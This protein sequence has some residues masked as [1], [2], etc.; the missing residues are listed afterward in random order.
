MS[1]KER[2]LIEQVVAGWRDKLINLTGKNRLLNFRPG[3]RS[4]LLIEEP[5]IA[6][7]L[8][9][10]LSGQS[11]QIISTESEEES[12]EL[13]DEGEVTSD[14][15]A[16]E[17]NHTSLDPRSPQ[18][19][20]HSETQLLGSP[21]TSEDIR[22]NLRSL[23]DHQS[24]IYLD[25][26]LSVS[27]L[28]IGILEW[29]DP[30]TPDKPFRS[31]LILVPVEFRSLSR[32]APTTL[33]LREDEIATNR[34]LALKLSSLAIDLPVLT[35]STSE[36]L[37]DYLDR[38]EQLAKKNRGWS[39]ERTCIASYFTFHKEAMYQD[40]SDHMDSIAQSELVRAL[41]TSGTDYVSDNLL[42]EP[43]NEVD[44][45]TVDVPEKALQ[46]LDADAS[47]RA[48]IVA[49]RD[50]QSFVL[51]GPPG[52]GKSQTIANIIANQ[53]ALG[54][55]V[56][57]V[58]EK[59]AALEVVK[60][61]LD[62]IGLGSYLLELHSAKAKRSVVAQD[63]GKS[64]HKNAQAQH[65]LK[66]S[67][68]RT[69][70]RNRDALTAYAVAMNSTQNSLGISLHDAIGQIALYSVHPPTP[71]AEF[72][73]EQ[74]DED[75]LAEVLDA[76][77][78]L[79]RAW[80][81]AT[82]GEGFLWAGAKST[83]HP[84]L[85]LQQAIDALEELRLV[86]EPYSEIGET[87]DWDCPPG[88]G[89]TVDLLTALDEA[90][91][92]LPSD[93]LTRED[94]LQTVA[95]AQQLSAL[96][97]Q[98]Q[99]EEKRLA[100]VA[101]IRWRDLVEHQPESTLKKAI[102]P[103][104][105][106]RP[107]VELNVDSDRETLNSLLNGLTHAHS[108]L[109]ECREEANSVASSLGLLPPES[110]QD[111]KDLVEIHDRATGQYRPE[112]SWFK[113][114][115]DSDVERAITTLQALHT[116]RNS[117][118]SK[119][120][121][122]F[123]AKILEANPRELHIRFSNQHTGL[124]RLSSARREDKRLVQE[125]CQA[126]VSAKNAIPL[127]TLAVTW[128]S[129]EEEL[130]KGIDRYSELLGPRYQGDETDWEALQKALENAREIAH[131]ARASAFDQLAQAAAHGSQIDLL[132]RQ[133]VA[134]LG[135]ALEMLPEK[136]AALSELSDTTEL[137]TWSL[138][139]QQTWLEQA[140]VGVRMHIE[141][142]ADLDAPLQTSLT[143]AQAT[144]VEQS[145]REVNIAQTALD[146]ASL[147][148]QSAFPEFSNLREVD[149]D[150]LMTHLEHAEAIREVASQIPSAPGETDA[151][152]PMTQDVVSLARTAGSPE[153]LSAAHQ[154]WIRSRDSIL[155]YFEVDNQLQLLGWFSTWA[156]SQEFLDGLSAD[157]SGP[158]E[159]HSYC[160]ARSR[161]ETWGLGEIIDSLAELQVRS[162]DVPTIIERE[163]LRPWVDFHLSQQTAFQNSLSQ[164]RDSLVSEFA[165]G[166]RQLI[167]TAVADIIDLA[168]SRKP[169]ANV[170]ASKKID[171]EA[172]K[173]TRHIPIRELLD[174]T[175]SVSQKLKPVF[176]MSPLAVSQF[177]SSSLRFDLVIFDE[178][179]QVLPEDAINCI[180][181]ADQLIIA[182]D[183]NQLPP[184]SFF[185]IE[186][187]QQ[188]EELV[189]EHS[190]AQDFESILKIAKGSGAF[191]TLTLK[192][193][194]RSRHE[195][196]ITFSNQRFYRGELVTFP[197]TITNGPDVGVEFLKVPDGVYARGGARH[198]LPE[199]RFVAQRIAHHYD[200]RPKMSLGIVALSQSQ[201]DAIEAA[202]DELIRER[203]ALERHIDKSRLDGLFV[204]NLESVQGDERDVMIMS[205]GYGPDEHG[206]F[207]MN[208][209]PM[210]RDGGWRRLNVAV[211][212]AR[213]R[214]EVVA[215]FDPSQI[216][217]SSQKSVQALR[218]YLDY[219]YRGLEALAFDSTSSLGDA[220]SPFEE[221]V[222]QWLTNEGF[223]VVPQVGTS[224]YR[225]DMAVQRPG[226]PGQFVLGIECDGAAYHRSKAARDRDRLR[227]EVLTRLGWRLHR[228]WGTSWYRS[229]EHEQQRLRRAIEQAIAEEQTST[230]PAARQVASIPTNV[231]EEIEI[232]L[233]SRPEWVVPYTEA[234]PPRPPRSV[235]PTAPDAVPHF[236][237]TLEILIEDEGP[238]HRE[239]LIQRLKQ[240]W[241]ITR[242]TP[243]IQRNLDKSLHRVRKYE[244]EDF[245]HALDEN[246]VFPTRQHQSDNRRKITHIH[247][248]EIAD[249]AWQI[250]QAAVEI[251]YD[252]LVISTARYLGFSRLVTEVKDKIAVI[253]DDMLEDGYLTGDR[254][255]LQ[256]VE[257]PGEL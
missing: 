77:R 62:E 206:K 159:W 136:F 116:S 146:D 6:G 82:A 39:V 74:L 150:E 176:M 100:E 50:G 21:L 175:A 61:R 199:A 30:E 147:T 33:S 31:P 53:L 22:S 89:L 49:A 155:D 93:L 213:Y 48:A 69:L 224:G 234:K 23:F 80:R 164:D 121:T 232:D 18:E 154:I 40:L 170:G 152:I 253:V 98:L 47:Q 129:A 1:D 204:K 132:T 215:S 17:R 64:L 99:D 102:E 45:D 233:E 256:W 109:A 38:I 43:T 249:T 250:A 120:E 244:D 137:Q 12:L 3:K 72:D 68:R 187:V 55:T 240:T 96:V 16:Q 182:G 163:L 160:N 153:S 189:D 247:P 229:R 46:V 42:F 235:A 9:R 13:V 75:S 114:D 73:V 238:I 198:N 181:R 107:S 252:D 56:L 141:V 226:H 123:Q 197:G 251:S 185:E 63:L 222:L 214:N 119:A 248:R 60:N 178:A 184:T 66:K 227:E 83:D 168:N 254:E 194:Y 162:D 157:D 24:T 115:V 208:F 219:A 143:L 127:L 117:A 195:D 87:L 130:S 84:S 167:S 25:A 54:R 125:A 186:E 207:T 26:G 243:E 242:V 237:K 142:L 218:Q 27:Y 71:E 95:A 177:L 193:H 126:G 29:I 228:I 97:T 133:K 78:A 52:T 67:D 90:P 70:E 246:E 131:K 165:N 144:Q 2:Q 113:T 19:R 200:T 76:A 65:S 183:D 28:A 20:I 190:S 212:R 151:S 58:S 241:G 210:N 149:V 239:I 44:I 35:G 79:S 209:G 57:F 135:K 128:Q 148:I 221:S 112:A 188:Q 217:E 245:F 92:S 223:S 122:Y 111:I 134:S 138:D 37:L 108:A 51:E 145:L 34:A 103:L 236:T 7:L 91:E 166:D 88:V 179:S 4:S 257:E 36:D 202:L 11:L 8:D 231:V 15:T 230:L 85:A 216:T 104:A 14:P 205:I 156:S 5:D 169:T 106:L 201:A 32:R 203:P 101:G 59:I 158:A 110:T 81:P 171:S 172:Q 124:K 10:V 211:T 191:T 173:K 86:Y 41:A 225:I 139:N 192:W 118:R 105:E 94:W 161:L 255:R 220:E 180:Y 174:K 140:I 196:L